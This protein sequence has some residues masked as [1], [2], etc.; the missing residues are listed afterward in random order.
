MY[1]SNGTAPLVTNA[2]IVGGVTTDG[3]LSP[4][5]RV[6]P[7]NTPRTIRLYAPNFDITVPL[8]TG[9]TFRLAAGT[10]L[11]KHIGPRP[12][13]HVGTILDRS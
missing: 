1:P 6:D 9:Q 5:S 13:I 3:N 11:G 10:S 2:L 4:R 8:P 7:P 12:K